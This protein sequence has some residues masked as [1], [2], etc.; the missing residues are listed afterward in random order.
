MGGALPER[1]QCPRPDE[2]GYLEGYR[3][4]ESFAGLVQLCCI[5]KRG[6]I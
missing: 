5:Q 4:M 1:A 2:C 3:R 6:S